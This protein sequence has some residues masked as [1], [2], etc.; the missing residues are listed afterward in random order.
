[1][2]V[3]DILIVIAV[4]IEAF[5][6]ARSGL[7]RGVFSLGGFL[8]GLLGGAFLVPFVLDLGFVAGAG[9]QLLLAVLIMLTAAFGGE[10]IGR[11][12][13]S[14][15]TGFRKKARGQRIDGILGAAFAACMTLFIAWLLAAALAGGPVRALNM[16][17]SNSVIIS[18]LNQQLP[19]AP[20]VLSQ[21]SSLVGSSLFPD[22]FIGPEPRPVEPVNPPT[23]GEV[24]EAL[25]N[26]GESTVRIEG[27]GCGGLKTGSGFIA[28]PGLIV[29][30]AHVVAGLD[31]PTV[32][33]INGK[34][35]AT[36]V[37]FNPDLD[38]A[39]LRADGL[40]GDPLNVA[41]QAFP[42][43]TSA[44]ALGY[45]GGQSLEADPAGVLQR[46]QARG[47]DIYGQDPVTRT[48]YALQTQIDQGNS[49]GP[50]VLP[51]GTVIGVVFAESVTRPDTGYA[52]T[53]REVL[54]LIQ[55][56][57]QT[58]SAIDTGRCTN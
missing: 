4:A 48:V 12:I 41:N 21:I 31:N 33:D 22:V 23:E 50:V 52:V 28:A 55:Q 17:I 35:A 7:V 49:G 45:P 54:P 25:A 56:A 47:R 10:T 26:A 14:K 53:S 2:N 27:L 40:A 42:R 38:I 19:P 46:L 5:V 36:P 15:L 6:W 11:L 29:T 24:A 8:L 37:L 51:D 30:N 3:L 32:V 16:Q 44:V 13:S 20:K 57:Q 39:V 18:S 34:R 9:S 58:R 43:G 1:M